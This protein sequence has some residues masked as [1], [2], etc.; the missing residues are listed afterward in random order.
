LAAR[1]L[2]DI[3]TTGNE[4]RD[5]GE[6]AAAAA[7]Y[8]GVAEVA[9]DALERVHDEEGELQE[10]IGACVDG[11]CRCFEST[12]ADDRT[13]RT[14]LMRALFDLYVADESH[15]GLCA[16]DTI[17]DV[18]IRQTMPD[19]HTLLAGWIREAFPGGQ[20]WS[21]D[22]RRDQFGELLLQL[23]GESL[24]DEAY[25]RVCR[26]TGRTDDL[27]ERLLRL[28]R[29]RDALQEM[30]AAADH[31]LLAL[32]ECFVAHG[33]G[34]HAEPIV[35][36]RAAKA[37]SPFVGTMLEWLSG[38]AETRGDVGAACALARR[39]FDLQPGLTRF[40]DIHRFT[41]AVEW[42]GVRAELRAELERRQQ[43]WLLLDIDLHEGDVA[44][45]V[46]RV[47]GGRHLP[48]RVLD[49]AKAAE[50]TL[51]RESLALY[52][53]AA[54]ALI[55]QRHRNAYRTACEHLLKVR[56]L[57]LRLGDEPAW[58]GYIQSL[59]TRFR[60]LRAFREELDHA[61]LI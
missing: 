43:E 4:F 40:N 22:Y 38:R 3:V 13:R 25:L 17:F 49:V 56:S 27:V 42:P 5:R 23:E 44:A 19:E 41:P 57:S 9:L 46:A 29:Q 37:Q 31:Q 14:A 48:A 45:A 7:A 47:V 61:K 51:P 59:R 1:E 16:G 21:D 8:R 33:L 34:D 28:G 50:K 32:A 55:E 58:T 35:R 15:G 20:G 54:E 52:R 11:L 10:V 26:E 24:D 18:F 2:H 36:A 53:T 60:P 6:L 30:N 39:L 12:A